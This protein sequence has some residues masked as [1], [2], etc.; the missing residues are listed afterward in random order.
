MSRYRKKHRDPPSVS[1]TVQRHLSLDRPTES[2]GRALQADAHA[3]AIAVTRETFVGPL[4]PPALLGEYEEAL[5]GLAERIVVMAEN[6]GCHRRAIENRL[7]RLSEFGLASGFLLSLAA[8]GGAMG[9]AWA[10]KGLLG[11]APLLVSVVGIVTVFVLRR[12][13]APADGSSSPA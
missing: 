1:L 2:G 8:I 4:P 7:M 6:E 12:D 11:L 10:G 13:A 9:L 3:T 5:P